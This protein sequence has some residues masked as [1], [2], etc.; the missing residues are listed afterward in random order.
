LNDGRILYDRLAIVN[1]P[2]RVSHAILTEPRGLFLVAF[3][4]YKLL[5]LCHPSGVRAVLMDLCLS[6]VLPVLPRGGM[7]L[8]FAVSNTHSP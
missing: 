3:G 2:F 8:E 1:G 4:R 7:S 5:R 6:A